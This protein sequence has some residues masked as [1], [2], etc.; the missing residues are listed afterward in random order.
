MFNIWMTNCCNLACKYCYEGQDKNDN[1][2]TM[3]KVDLLMQFIERYNIRGEEVLVNFHGGEPILEIDTIE[4]II[5]RVK[6]KYPCAS[7]GITTNGT[8]MSDKIADILIDCGMEITVS[9][10]GNQACHD[11]Y[12]IYKSGKGTHHKVMSTIKFLQNKGAKNMRY[13]LTFNSQTVRYLFENI[14][15]LAEN[16]IKEVVPAPDYFDKN[17]EDASINEF[18]KNVELLKKMKTN[19]QDVELYIPYTD[20]SEIKQKGRCRG[21]MGAY[22]IDAN[23]DLYPCVFTVGNKDYKLGSLEEGILENKIKELEKIYLE[24]PKECEGCDFTKYCTSYRCKFLNELLCG[25]IYHV[26]PLVCEFEHVIYNY[27]CCVNQ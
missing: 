7:L 4:E 16:G 25:N 1:R 9:I 2:F 17:W 19:N 15:W 6:K 13:R 24:D 27:I 21:G 20:K 8:I 26:S 12:R 14:R 22:H 18:V 5:K 23:G 10:D 11:K 3:D